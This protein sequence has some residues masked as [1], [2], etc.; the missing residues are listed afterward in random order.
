MSSPFPS[1]FTKDALQRFFLNK[2]IE[3]S[4]DMLYQHEKLTR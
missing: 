3:M 2:D 4:Y 1:A